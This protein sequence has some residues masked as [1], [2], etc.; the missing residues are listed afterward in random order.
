M[1]A[2]PRLVI[3]APSSGHGKSVIAIGLLAALRGRDLPAAG[4]KIGPDYIDAA[5]LGLAAGRPAGNLDPRM[6]GPDLIAPL[7]R[8]GAAGAAIAV[9]EGTMGLYDGLGGAPD[10]TS[11]AQVAGLLRAPV[12]LVVDA[13]AM[14]QSVAALVHGFRGYD[15]MV[16]LAGA[17]LNRVTSDR[18]EQLLRASLD[19]I[20]VPVFGAL[21]RHQ[22]AEVVLPPRDRG[23]VPVVQEAVDAR[24]GVR[25]LGEVVA[26]AV[27]LDRLV[28]L[29]RSAPGLP[30]AAWPS[31][32]EPGPA[33]PVAVSPAPGGSTGADAEPGIRR[34]VVAVAG[35]AR[36]S[37]GYDGVAD[38]LGE[39]GAVVVPI[40][41][42]RDEVLP[43]GTAG[44]VLGG[45]LPEAYTDEFAANTGLA[46]SL[47]ALA[48][49]GGPIMAEGTGLLLL[50]REYA[51]QP[52]AGVID[53][54]GVPGEHLALGYRE[55][56]AVT[57]APLLPAGTAVVGYRRHHGLIAPRA[58]E[59]PAWSWPGAAP[60]GFV[61]GHLHASLLCL[62]WAGV[63]EIAR[64]LVAAARPVVGLA[65]AA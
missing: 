6:V 11:T 61:A 50:L 54:T 1:P 34:P 25:R 12:L 48:R 33:R 64:R 21:R 20:G 31:E 7:F 13:A 3:A 63:P 56:V 2:A 51:G 41:P 52:M 23:V 14:G 45:A 9:V 22:L 65:A 8:Q 46:R 4:F 58:S 36:F 44:V 38:L 18:H 35:G 60:E 10:T 29:A 47:R 16:W 26:A 5:Y 28:A 32:S 42:L 53:A 15:E 19:D 40:D 39:A 43:P 30:A 27:D 24:R 57:P 62:H 37:Y 49:A 59:R 17:I 55:A